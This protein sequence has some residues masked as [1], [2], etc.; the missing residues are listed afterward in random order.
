MLR[1]FVS[2]LPKMIMQTTKFS[3]RSL[4][5]IW[6]LSFQMQLERYQDQHYSPDILRIIQQAFSYLFSIFLVPSKTR[7][8]RRK[9]CYTFRHESQDRNCLLFPPPFFFFP[10][11][12]CID[13][14]REKK[15]KQPT[16]PSDTQ[17]HIPSLHH[18]KLFLRII[19]RLQRSLTLCC[20]I[21]F[22]FW[23]LA[24]DFFFYF[25]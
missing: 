17:A 23:I 18:F 1:S 5:S 22:I 6:A 24:S 25:S 19:L 20:C 12:K 15:L 8:G 13:R 7:V 2:V 4:S 16:T 11:A 9:S 3:F 21:T 10:V 14:L